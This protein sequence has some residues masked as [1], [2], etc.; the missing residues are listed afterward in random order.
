MP[1]FQH[2]GRLAMPKLCEAERRQVS[3]NGYYTSF[4]SLIRRFDSAHLLKKIICLIRPGINA[5]A[6]VRI[7]SP[8]NGTSEI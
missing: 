7:V 5:G 2:K 1:K 6:T 3:Y 4:P 8:T